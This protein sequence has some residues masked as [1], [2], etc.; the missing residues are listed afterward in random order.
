MTKTNFSDVVESL[1]H[2]WLFATPSTV[3]HQASLSFVSWSLLKL[4]SIGDTIQQSHPLLPTS[5]S[6]FNLS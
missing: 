1:S 5:L 3:A 2:V 4:M 6:A